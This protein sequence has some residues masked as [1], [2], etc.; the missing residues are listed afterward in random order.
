M[1]KELFTLEL[2]ISDYRGTTRGAF[3]RE[4]PE[5]FIKDIISKIMSFDNTSSEF[6]EK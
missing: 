4:L 5:E 1:A 2:K 6:M 3:Q